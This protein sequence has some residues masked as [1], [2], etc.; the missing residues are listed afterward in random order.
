MRSHTFFGSLAFFWRLGPSCGLRFLSTNKG[1]GLSPGSTNA[2][3]Q[4]NKKHIRHIP[5][6]FRSLVE[7]GWP[8]G[9]G[10]WISMR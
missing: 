8:S 10:Y 7:E 1:R 2:K 4:R 6:R 9:F 5:A 3:V